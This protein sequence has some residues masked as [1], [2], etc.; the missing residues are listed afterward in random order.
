[1]VLMERYEL[2]HADGLVG[3]R[4]SPDGKYCRYKDAK[5]F[6]EEAD[7]FRTAYNG[8]NHKISHLQAENA[9]LKERAEKA[10]VALKKYLTTTGVFNEGGYCE[11]PL[12]LEAFDKQIEDLAALK[13]RL[14]PIEAVYERFRHLDELLSDKEW[15]DTSSPQRH[16]LYD[17]WQ[18]IKEAEYES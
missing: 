3:L 18:A 16:C 9:A 15:I 17:L 8:L 4:T 12:I 1:V 11:H 13:A 14:A 2:A 7:F 5:Q 6:E 10:E